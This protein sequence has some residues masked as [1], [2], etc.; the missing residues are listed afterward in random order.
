L[1]RVYI[2]KSIMSI[3][4]ISDFQVGME[5]NVIMVSSSLNNV[6]FWFGLWLIYNEICI[7]MRYQG[8]MWLFELVSFKWNSYSPWYKLNDF[9]IRSLHMMWT[10]FS[11]AEKQFE[12][13]VRHVN[14]DHWWVFFVL[15]DRGYI[16]FIKVIALCYDFYTC[17]VIFEAWEQHE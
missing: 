17:C 3:R 5:T 9:A 15:L 7:F 8:L 16:Y 14:A 10:L 6:T 13:D 11:T 1:I 4:L 2:I 12:Y